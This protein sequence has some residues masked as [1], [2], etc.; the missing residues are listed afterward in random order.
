MSNNGIDIVVLCGWFVLVIKVGM[1][2]LV[3]VE[4][5]YGNIVIIDYGG[6]LLVLYVY[7]VS[8]SVGNGVWVM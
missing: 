3:L 1:V 5:G 6:G 8:V 4:C 2:V 7:F